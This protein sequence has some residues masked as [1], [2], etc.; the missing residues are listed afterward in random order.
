MA[1]TATYNAPENDDAVVTMQGVRFFD[2]QAKEL[3]ERAHAELIDKL[4]TN[5]HFTLNE[6][7]DTEFNPPTAQNNGW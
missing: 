4:R 1:T 7:G 6:G 5:Q 2:G 3:D